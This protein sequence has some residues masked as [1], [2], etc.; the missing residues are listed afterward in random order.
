MRDESGRAR[1]DICVA[2]WSKTYIKRGRRVISC[3]KRER[4]I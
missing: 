1:T 2:E 4:K 3:N